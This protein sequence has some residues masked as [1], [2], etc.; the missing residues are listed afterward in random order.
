MI[1]ALIGSYCGVEKVDGG[2]KT[3]LSVSPI[4]SPLATYTFATVG[5]SAIKSP[6]NPTTSPP[7][8]RS[9]SFILTFLVCLLHSEYG[10]RSYSLSVVSSDEEGVSVSEV[11]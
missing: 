6:T 5:F 10:F 2:T 4:T 8:N 7:T 3:R 11:G 1:A 9:N